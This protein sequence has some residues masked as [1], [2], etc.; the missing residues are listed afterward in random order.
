M[1]P[2]TWIADSYFHRE[3]SLDPAPFWNVPRNVV[4]PS[5]LDTDA[6]TEVESDIFVK[7]SSERTYGSSRRD[8]VFI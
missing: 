4:V 8:E 1:L 2:L 6:F 7:I 3:N 5:F